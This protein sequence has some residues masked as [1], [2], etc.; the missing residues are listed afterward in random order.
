MVVEGVVGALV[1]LLRSSGLA[2]SLIVG[3]VVA[4]VALPILFGGLIYMLL[5][6]HYYKLYAPRDFSDPQDFVRVLDIGRQ[7]AERLG[8]RGAARGNQPWLLSS[9]VSGSDLELLETRVHAWEP[10]LDSMNPEEFL[11]IHSWY[12]E[13]G[14]HPHALVAI[15]IAIARGT[16][17]SQAFSYRSASLRKLG[18]LLEAKTCASLAL[19]F[20]AAN[21]D[22]HYNLAKT[23]LAAGERQEAVDHARVALSTGHETYANQL[24]VLFPELQ[25][26]K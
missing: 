7:D 5:T 24:R 21:A 1:L 22:A 8:R 18:R 11:A 20:D 16:I 14:D 6:R 2:P 4:S 15:D 19:T 9:D 13:R 10:L 25:P 17:T 3:L 23:L 26:T 12:N